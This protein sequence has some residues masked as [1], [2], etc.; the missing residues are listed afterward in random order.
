MI[1][2]VVGCDGHRVAS[3]TPELYFARV[4]L[5]APQYFLLERDRVCE[6]ATN[7][8]ADVEFDR[9]NRVCGFF[10]VDAGCDFLVEL[11]RHFFSVGVVTETDVG[12]AH[13]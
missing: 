11:D 13:C 2:L 1:V 5:L 10:F 3:H 7:G 9:R 8:L 6:A 12:V 4:D